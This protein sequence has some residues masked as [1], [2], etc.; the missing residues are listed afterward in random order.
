MVS[1]TTDDYRALA[2]AGCVA[3]T[4]PAFWAGF[5]RRGPEAWADY[6]DQLTRHEP[7][8]A[9]AF[10]IRHYC[11]L[12]INPKEAHDTAAA[13]RVID[14]IPP[15]LERPTVL[16]IG[17]IGLNRNTAAELEIFN[18]QL[19]LA[20]DH[21]QLVLVHTPHLEDKRRGTR[22]ILE[23][24]ERHG[25]LDPA[26]VL[27]DHVEEHTVGDVLARGFWAGLTLYPQTKATP[28]RAADMIERHGHDRLWANS[29]CDWGEADA[30][31]VPRLRH[32]LRMR[33]HPP[34]L[35]DQV[36][37]HNPATFLAQSGRF[38]VSEIL[39]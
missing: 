5:D 32:T 14:L 7:V 31:A 34:S 17:E 24:L 23:A 38:N 10:G 33:G 18:A 30:L 20:A 29:A 11:W 21:N 25:R 35:I 28:D 15:L 1:R 37:L 2:Q 39:D 9:A 6:F 36:T 26:R 27:I 3:V 13:R 4:E 22:L 19:D 16:G 8:R 12:C